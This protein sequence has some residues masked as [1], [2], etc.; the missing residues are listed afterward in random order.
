MGDRRQAVVVSG[1][2]TE[3]FRL[4]PVGDLLQQWRDLQA[5]HT[6]DATSGRCPVCKVRD[7]ERWRWAGERL[8]EEGT[9][10]RAPGKWRDPSEP[11]EP[12]P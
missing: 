2:F 8:A 10:P 5:Q 12:Q 4:P 3:D 9:L 11:A 7:C 6:N 1:P